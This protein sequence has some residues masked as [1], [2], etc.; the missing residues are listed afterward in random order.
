VRRLL[1]AGIAIA[2]F[3]AAASAGCRAV[4][5]PGPA[6]GERQ[7]QAGSD[8][9]GAAEALAV[10]KYSPLGE[11]GGGAGPGLSGEDFER[12]RVPVKD[13]WRVGFPDQDRRTG[14]DA[15]G[16][17]GAWWDPYHQ[18]VLKGDYPLPGTQNLFLV[19]EGVGTALGEARRT[20][21]PSGVFPK[22]GGSGSPFFRDG[23]ETLLDERFDLSLDLFHGETSYKPVDWRV[24]VRGVFDANH[25]TAEE[26]T[27]LFAD[28]SKGTD[29]N[30]RFGAL[31]E[32]FF[33]T[34]L[35]TVSPDYDVIQARVGIQRFNADFRGFL[36]LDDALGVRV[37]GSLDDNRWQWNLALFDRRDKDTNSGLNELE[38]IG[39]RLLVLNLY[40]QDL[41]EGLAPAGRERSWSR[42]LTGQLA[43]VRFSDEDSVDYDS[44]GFLVRP[45]AVGAVRP[46]HRD[47]D[48]LGANL[49]GHVGRVN[50]V[51]SL[52]H[53]SG[54]VSF[55]EIAGRSQTVDANM[56]A[57][58]LSMDRDWMRFK[59]FGFYQSGDS[60]PRDG[61]AEG[62]DAVFDNPSF[63][64]GEFGFWNRNAVRLVGTGVGLVQR[65]SLLNSLRSSKDEGS[66]SYV[67]PGLLLAG[68]GWDAQL[69]PRLK[70][71]TN[72]SY[73]VFDDT[74]SLEQVLNQSAIGREIGWDLSVG[75]IWRPL[76]TENVV[77]KGGVAA[78]VPG[79]G[80]RDVYTGEVLYTAFVELELRW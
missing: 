66:P 25:A 33:E 37:F 51:A 9:A 43:Y 38:S 34:T 14:S 59:V 40:R 35:A 48:Y 2:A 75:A 70:L 17:R 49:D 42:G 78:L 18:N 23:E 29:R 8:E 61:K 30:D 68:V 5:T 6:E 57:L 26:N 11:A 12:D 53:A 52:Y 73:L 1:R 32:A 63:A 60:D 19:V 77:V 65:G 20:P 28:P 76:L 45:R 24:L 47:V 79:H 72:A 36:F 39:Q 71:L 56:A 16:D 62:F 46:N 21:T 7:A 10:R 67:N 3:A 44:N 41:L 80:F 50:V 64:G 69:T 22:G 4:P 74:A 15:P 54:D 27:V 55:D 31:Q 13:R 58:E